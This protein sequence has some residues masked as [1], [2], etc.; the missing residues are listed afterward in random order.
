MN[1]TF[2]PKAVG[3]Y[4]NRKEFKRQVHGCLDA[5][6]PGREWDLTTTVLQPVS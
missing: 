5:P 3:K 6:F 4:V 1:L 2:T